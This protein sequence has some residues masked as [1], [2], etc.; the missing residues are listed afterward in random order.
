MGSNSMLPNGGQSTCPLNQ[1]T[2][3]NQSTI[4]AD[5]QHQEMSHLITNQTLRFGE[6]YQ[7]Y[8]DASTGNKIDIHL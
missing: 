5:V 3:V 4:K 2:D 7:D 1:R 6:Y 8:L